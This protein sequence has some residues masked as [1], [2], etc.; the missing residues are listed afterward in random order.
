VENEITRVRYCPACGRLT[1]QDM[2][3]GGAAAHEPMPT[4]TRP[5]TIW[6]HI[7]GGPDHGNP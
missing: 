5:I 4:L 2:C 6:D 3:D 7:L 1:Q